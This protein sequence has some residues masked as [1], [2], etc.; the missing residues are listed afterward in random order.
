VLSEEQYECNDRGAQPNP[1]EI[2]ASSVLEIF[3]AEKTENLG[4]R[5]QPQIEE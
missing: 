1:V 2:G 5:V 3:S 4:A